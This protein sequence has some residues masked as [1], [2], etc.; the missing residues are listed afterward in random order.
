MLRERFMRFLGLWDCLDSIVVFEEKVEE[1]ESEDVRKIIERESDDLSFWK[2]FL[3]DWRLW[4]QEIR[5]TY[6]KKG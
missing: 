4:I 5:T 2:G 6:G 1:A 3:M